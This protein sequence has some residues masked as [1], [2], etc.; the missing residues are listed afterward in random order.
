[1]IY[2][3]LTSQVPIFFSRQVFIECCLRARHC[4]KR[5]GYIADKVDK[6]ACPDGAFILARRDRQ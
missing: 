6:D 3:K 4:S 2:I 1:M 5:L